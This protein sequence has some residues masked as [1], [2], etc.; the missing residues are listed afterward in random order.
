LRRHDGLAIATP[1]V[2]EPLQIGARHGA[3]IRQQQQR[4]AGM[5]G[6][7]FDA[8]ADGSRQ[9]LRPATIDHQRDG[10]ARQAW[11]NLRGIRAQHHADGVASHG[12]GATQRQLHHRHALNPGELLGRSETRAGAGREHDEVQIRGSRHAT[13]DRGPSEE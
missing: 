7:V 2:D 6:Q 4:A 11:R 9:A 3:L 10:G 12:F 13:C 1:Y 8:G 5:P